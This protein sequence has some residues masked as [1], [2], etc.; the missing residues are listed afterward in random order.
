MTRICLNILV[1]LE[2]V[3]NFFSSVGSMKCSNNTSNC[4]TYVLSVVTISVAA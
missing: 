2:Q 3:I 1:R 4:S